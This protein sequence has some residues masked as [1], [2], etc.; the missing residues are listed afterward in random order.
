MK[1]RG[2]SIIVEEKRSKI[3]V[4]KSRAWSVEY[5]VVCCKVIVA[6]IIISG[7]CRRKSVQ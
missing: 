7:M 5:L 3:R 2:R 4:T 1:T 6:F